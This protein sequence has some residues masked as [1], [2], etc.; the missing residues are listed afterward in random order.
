MIISFAH[1]TP[2]LVAG[3]KTV[4][5]RDWKPGHAAK[6]KAGQVVDA[7][8]RNPRNGGTLVA[9]IELT[10]DPYLAD[11]WLMPQSDYEAEGFEY[12]HTLWAGRNAAYEERYS[13]DQ[14]EAWR[15]QS[16]MLWVVRF[17]LVELCDLCRTCRPVFV[18]QVG[19]YGRQVT[20]V[21]EVL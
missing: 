14:F 2:A 10:G 6:F 13:R 3:H 17:R 11:T 12:L 20:V 8:D 5:R 9:R 1:T 16:Q 7:Y 15:Q 21:G 4:T 19:K 18:A